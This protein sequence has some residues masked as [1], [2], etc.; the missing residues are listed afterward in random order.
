MDSVKWCVDIDL[1]LYNDFMMEIGKRF[2]VRRGVIQQAR[3]EA[4]NDWIKKNTT[5]DYLKC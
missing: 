3:N 1:K 2:G 5:T 4:I